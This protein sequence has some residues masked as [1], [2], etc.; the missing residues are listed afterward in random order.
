MRIALISALFLLACSEP[1]LDPADAS[2]TPPDAATIDVDAGAVDADAG[3]P[4]AGP[5]DAGPAWTTNRLGQ[6]VTGGECPAQAGGVALNC[7]PRPPGGFCA[8]CVADTD[9]PPRD[10]RTYA[11]RFGTCNQACTADTDCPTGLR[12]HSS[13]VC[14]LVPCSSG[15]AVPYVCE[16]DFCVRRPCDSTCPAGKCQGGYCADDL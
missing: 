12:C 9:C 2:T 14:V 16:G 4:D 6:C 5:V 1:S 11:C 7:T 8:G 3:A 13:G 15:C 10:G